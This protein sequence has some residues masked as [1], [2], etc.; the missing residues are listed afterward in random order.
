MGLPWSKSTRPREGQR[1]AVFWK[2]AQCRKG[3]SRAELSN[4][5]GAWSPSYHS[6]EGLLQVLLSRSGA[7]S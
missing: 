7:A 3:K 2:W 1:G 5:R 4:Q 6:A